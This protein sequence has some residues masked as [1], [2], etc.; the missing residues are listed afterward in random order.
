[1][2]RLFCD[3]RNGNECD[4]AD[5]RISSNTGT[6]P[7]AERAKTTC[8][9]VGHSAGATHHSSGYGCMKSGTSTVETYWAH[10]KNHM[11]D[12]EVASS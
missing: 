5:V 7:I 1:M 12:L 3:D 9:E 6:L 11:N 2:R 8:H 4:N 10:T